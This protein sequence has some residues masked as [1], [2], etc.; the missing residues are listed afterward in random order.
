MGLIH[1]ICPRL[2]QCAERKLE[3]DIQEAHLRQL[4]TDALTQL[5]RA[6]FTGLRELCTACPKHGLRLCHGLL[7][8]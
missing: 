7:A 6:L 5:L 8:A 2:L 4:L 1:T 3:A